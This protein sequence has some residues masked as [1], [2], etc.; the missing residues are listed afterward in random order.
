[1]EIYTDLHNHVGKINNFP[2]FSKVIS[3][4]YNALGN[5]GIL[6][7]AGFGND[8]K[9]YETFLSKKDRDFLTLGDNTAIVPLDGEG[10]KRIIVIRCQE[11]KTKQ[12]EYL[13]VAPST[14]LKNDRPFQD[15]IREAK[16]SGGILIIPHFGIPRVGGGLG[17]FLESNPQILEKIIENFDGFEVYTSSAAIFPGANK[18]ALSF[19]LEHNLGERKI[20]ACSFTDSHTLN[21][22]KS[23]TKIEIDHLLES[24]LVPELKRG[25][26]NSRLENLIMEPSFIDPTIHAVEVV[27]SQVKERV[28]KIF[29]N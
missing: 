11:V 22:G 14:Y 4:A 5:Y 23:K 24:P 13:V 9:R 18:K 21:F 27:Y 10:N 7:I 20:G 28:G 25:I 6:G 19:Y 12:G 8:D 16:D 26:R 29:G 1:M 2:D 15:S 3:R 17:W